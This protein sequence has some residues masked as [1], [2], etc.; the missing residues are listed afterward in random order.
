M[1]AAPQPRTARAGV[2]DPTAEIPILRP[3]ARGAAVTGAS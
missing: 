3:A 2:H 1:P